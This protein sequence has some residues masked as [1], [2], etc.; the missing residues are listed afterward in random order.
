MCT[1]HT[2]RLPTKRSKGFTMRV[3]LT[4]ANMRELRA[5]SLATFIIGAIGS[6]IV[7]IPIVIMAYYIEDILL[8]VLLSLVLVLSMRLVLSKVFLAYIKLRG[9]LIRRMVIKIYINE[10]SKL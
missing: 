5:V 1:K 6:L 8:Q 4:K 10:Q 3:K 9:K 7:T 2:V